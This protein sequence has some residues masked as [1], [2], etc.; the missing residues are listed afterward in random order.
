MNGIQLIAYDNVNTMQRWYTALITMHDIQCATLNKMYA[1]KSM[2]GTCCIWINVPNVVACQVP[3][4][5][6]SKSKHPSPN[7]VK[8]RWPI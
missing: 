1:Y 8:N 6:Y 2:Y 4:G 5:T 3:P 7:R